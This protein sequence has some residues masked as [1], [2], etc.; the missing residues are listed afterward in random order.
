M[1]RSD[2]AI[3]QRLTCHGPTAESFTTF[4]R[5][6]VAMKRHA[7]AARE[8]VQQSHKLDSGTGRR[9]ARRLRA[10][11]LIGACLK[12]HEHE[13]AAGRRRLEQRL[14][15]MQLTQ[16]EM[17]DDG[18]CQF[19]AISQQLFGTQDL[20]AH[21]R[22]KALAH[23]CAH[24]D[25][26]ASF[27][28]TGTAEFDE[29]IR[30][31][32]QGKTWGDELTLKAASDA[33]KVRIHLVQSTEYNW[34]IV[35]EPSP[36]FVDRGGVANF[37]AKQLFITYIT[38]VHY[39]S[40]DPLSEELIAAAADARRVQREGLRAQVSE[41]LSSTQR[42]LS[43]MSMRAHSADAAVPHAGERSEANMRGH[44]QTTEPR[45]DLE[46]RRLTL[47]KMYASIQQYLSM[48]SDQQAMYANKYAETRELYARLSRE[49]DALLSVIHAADAR[50]ARDARTEVTAH[51][52]RGYSEHSAGAHAIGAVQ[53]I[54]A[55]AHSEPLQTG[56]AALPAGWAAL[57][58][59]ASGHTYY[60]H[61]ASATSQWQRPG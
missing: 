47:E 31:M 25:E 51:P 12:S 36:A 24:A 48:P 58:D 8:A 56:S 14:G 1:P 11:I 23:M 21:V 15:A 22:Q 53:P 30:A 10:P 50:H 44:A 5:A 35:Y 41:D 26:F 59:P 32:S 57:V 7:K 17:A 18:N 13:I 33:F 4:L 45:A 37:P 20:H 2:E 29:Y 60:V 55:R 3:L 16:S 28:E 19:R 43:A 40:I 38:P 49:Y 34:Y 61:A 9:F 42:M 52:V 27:F 54:I 6:V 39:N 46:P